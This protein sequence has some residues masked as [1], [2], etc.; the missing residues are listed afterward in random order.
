MKTKL[1]QYSFDTQDPAQK[2][3]WVALRKRLRESGARLFESAGG[4]R[5]HY[6]AALPAVTEVTLETTHL[7]SNQWN[8]API[9]GFSETESGLRVFDFALDAIFD[10]RGVKQNRF[11]RGHYLEQTADMRTVR[12]NTD[13][14]GYC[15]KQESAQK[16]Y[17]FCPH[18]IDSEYLKESELYLT[19]MQAIDVRE[20]R[21]P[22]T[23]A[24]R[25]HLV[26]LYHAA[27]LH[28]TTERGKA[29]LAKARAD[30]EDKYAQALHAATS[31]RDGARFIMAHMPGVL[32]NWIY[33]SHTDTHAFGWRKALSAG[34]VSVLLDAISEFPFPYKIECEDGRTL[35]GNQS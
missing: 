31:E 28:G 1:H 10:Y 32:G 9:E 22:L 23:D 20:D 6:M 33:Y 12:R 7:F 16:G 29:R 34:E 26:P 15:G 19:R 35:Q 30:I 25:A 4:N 8:T 2:A 11:K 24:E 5:S 18:C 17:T 13:A 27:Q 3:Q 21:A 14:C